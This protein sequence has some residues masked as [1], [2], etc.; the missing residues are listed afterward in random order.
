MALQ[1]NA[2]GV[3]KRF[4]TYTRAERWLKLTKY[5]LEIIKSSLKR[6]GIKQINFLHIFKFISFILVP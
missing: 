3:V 1:I 2:D 5:R 6:T 4:S